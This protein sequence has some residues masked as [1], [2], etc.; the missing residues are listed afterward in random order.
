MSKT[1]Y[2]RSSS[3]NFVLSIGGFFYPF[4]NREIQAFDQET[5]INNFFPNE[6]VSVFNET[7]TNVAN[8][9][10]NENI[11]NNRDPLLIKH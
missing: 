4:I 5:T 3:R 10:C 6:Q 11:C 9:L 1:R 8:F 7:V 2:L